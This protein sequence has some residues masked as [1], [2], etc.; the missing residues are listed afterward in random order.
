MD[1]QTV[2]SRMPLLSLKPGDIAVTSK[3][4]NIRD[5]QLQQALA[6]ATKGKEGKDFEAALRDFAAKPGSYQGIR[7]VRL[8]ESLQQSA[9][10]EVGT[11]QPRRGREPDKRPLKDYKGDSNYC[12]EVWRLPDGEVRQQV[13]TT[14]DAHTGAEKKPHPAAKR[15]LRVFKR[16]MVALERDGQAMIYYVQK[17][18]FV[19]GLFLAPHIEA[20]ADARNRDK[21]DPFKFIQ[22]GAGPLVK[23]GIRRVF[24]DEIGRVRDPGRLNI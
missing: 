4:K 8:I 2:V 14:F 7:R 17:L 16:D 3:G 23:A 5:P 18:D 22:I 19:N 15:L 20:N 13:V 10:V 6:A 1:D 21:S 12:Y 24:V 11:R 9:R